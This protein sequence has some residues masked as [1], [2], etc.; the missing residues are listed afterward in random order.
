MKGRGSKT[1]TLAFLSSARRV[2][3]SHPLLARPLLQRCLLSP[4]PLRSVD[5]EDAESFVALVCSSVSF[6]LRSACTCL[7]SARRRSFADLRAHVSS[8]HANNHESA[9]AVR[10]MADRDVTLLVTLLHQIDKRSQNHVH[11]PAAHLRV[12]LS[13][14][15]VG[16][17]DRGHEPSS[18]DGR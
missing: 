12:R 4:S 17:L 16:L 18:C 5:E 8:V 11:F 9:T 3:W 1:A 7:S 6:C 2:A 15:I 10:G 14:A 13:V